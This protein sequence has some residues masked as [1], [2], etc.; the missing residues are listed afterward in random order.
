MNFDFSELTV[1]ERQALAL[2]Q[3]ECKRLFG[4]RSPGRSPAGPLQQA[5]H[6]LQQFVHSDT[7]GQARRADAC[8][9]VWW[10]RGIA[11]NTSRLTRVLSKGR[12]WINEH[13][14]ELGMLLPTSEC[15]VEVATELSRLL[16]RQRYGA[17]Q[18]AHWTCRVQRPPFPKDL[19]ESWEDEWHPGVPNDDWC[20]D[21]EELGLL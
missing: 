1:E 10:S 3:G 12:S 11:V 14:A 5:L 17:K 19:P 4:R 13:L 21:S 8:G 9:I 18:A 20:L 16:G 6:E 15:Q 7:V 2:L